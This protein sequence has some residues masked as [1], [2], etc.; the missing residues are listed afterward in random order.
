MRAGEQIVVPEKVPA[1]LAV[2]LRRMVEIP[3]SARPTLREVYSELLCLHG[4]FSGAGH[5]AHY[6]RTVWGIPSHAPPS[7]SDSKVAGGDMSQNPAQM[8]SPPAAAS[9]AALSAAMPLV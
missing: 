7:Y 6:L 3:T 9:H 1:D 8:V 4:K 5:A 2:L